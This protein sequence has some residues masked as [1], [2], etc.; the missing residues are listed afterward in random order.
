VKDAI[1]VP[2]RSG[3]AVIGTLEVTGRLGEMPPFGP[4]DARL[5][6]TLAAHRCVRV[7]NSRLIDRLR[8]DAYH[9]AL[10]SLPNRRRVLALLEEAVKVRAPDEVV[11]V[12]LFDSDGLRD[13]NDSLGH[14]AG[15]RMVSEVAS[16][17]RGI[18]PSAALVG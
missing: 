1:V 10:T 5:V 8:F 17:L 6:G 12:L 2:L 18:A 11:A 15:D 16:R 14:D 7:E 3:S 9:D 4:A 13:V